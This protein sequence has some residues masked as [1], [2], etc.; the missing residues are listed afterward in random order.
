MFSRKFIGFFISW[1]VFGVL[2]N[3]LINGV[4]MQLKGDYLVYYVITL[5]LTMLFSFPVMLVLGVPVSMLSD[6]IIKRYKGQFRL[7]FS[8][9]IHTFFGISFGILLTFI[10]E[11]EVYFFA[12]LLASVIFWV[13]DELLRIIQKK[14]S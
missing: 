10:G 1:I 9:A 3:V 13:V 4:M 7:I 5:A 14:Q 8:F 2:F 6:Y 12:S 11:V